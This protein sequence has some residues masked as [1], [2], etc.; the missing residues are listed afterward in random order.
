MNLNWSDLFQ[1]YLLP[2]F[3]LN[4]GYERYAQQSRKLVS[5]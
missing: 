3:Y 1:S 4:D 2:F 5:T